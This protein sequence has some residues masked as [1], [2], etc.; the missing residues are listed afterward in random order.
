MTKHPDN[1]FDHVRNRSLA[2]IVRFSAKPQ[3]FQESVAEHSFYVAYIARMLCDLL[4]DKNITI[5]AEK[6]ISMAL[7]HDMEEMYSGDIL[8]PFKH[9]S[10]KVRDAIREVNR[11]LI[12]TAFEDLPESLARHYVALW[13]EEN[14]QESIEARVVK[15]ADRLS[16]IAKCLEEIRAGNEFFKPIYE[17]ELKKLKDTPHSWWKEI[18]D[19]VLGEGV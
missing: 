6:T 15:I 2:H 3:H 8:S 12:Q 16:L 1:I 14:M 13:N 17:R 11:E 18:R 4:K 5:D 10:D 7:L 19:H 9:H